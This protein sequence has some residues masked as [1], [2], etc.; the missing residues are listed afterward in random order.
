MSTTNDLPCGAEFSTASPVCNLPSGHAPGHT[1]STERPRA[2]PVAKPTI[3]CLCGSTRFRAEFVGVNRGLTMAGEIV[4]APG[5]SA[6]DG[7]PLTE[8]EKERL[9][10]LH[11]RK[12]DLADYVYVVN[13]GGY[14]GDSTRREI[15]YAKNTGKPVTYLVP[16]TV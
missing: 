12:I 5:V 2:E 3:A 16:N 7:D 6:H 1:Y 13:P 15:A 4:V 10:A 9:D 14:I 8:Q 11:L